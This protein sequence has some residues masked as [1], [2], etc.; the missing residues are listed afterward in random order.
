MKSTDTVTELVRIPL[1]VPFE[2]FLSTFAS[3]LEPVLLAQPGIISILTGKII[4][5]GGSPRNFAVS[6]TQWENMDAHA[7]FLGSPAAKPFFET[8]EPLAKGPPIIEHY[9]LGTLPLTALRSAFVHVAIYN[10]RDGSRQPRVLDSQVETQKSG[11]RIRVEGSCLEV[12]GQNAQI[13]FSD[14]SD[15]AG[16]ITT[17]QVASF[18][19][20]IEGS[21]EKR[22]SS[23]KALSN[24]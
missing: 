1:A 11:K 7:A 5:P 20:C 9:Y 24:L 2:Y 19:V 18:V 6:I 10:S 16:T 23:Q 17:G 3:K 13:L 21:E 8:L 12:E 4:T 22:E 14:T 15:L